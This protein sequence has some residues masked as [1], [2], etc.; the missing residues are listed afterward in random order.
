MKKI[1]INVIMGLCLMLLMSLGMAQDFK[2]NDPKKEL[3]KQ[4]ILEN[5]EYPEQAALNNLEGEVY[6]RFI[7]D[8]DKNIQNV[9]ILGN[10]N[11]N[12]FSQAAIKAVY[13]LK[14]NLNNDALASNTVYR[15]IIDFEMND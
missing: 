7:T 10:Q 6:V 12:D 3:I 8:D 15:V 4:T 1:K 5:I 13:D 11:D 14:D 2:Q 9:R